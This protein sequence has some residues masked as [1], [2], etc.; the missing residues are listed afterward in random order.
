MNSEDKQAEQ[1][2]NQEDLTLRTWETHWQ[3]AVPANYLRN[4]SEMAHPSRDVIA[5]KVA[6]MGVTVLECGCASAIDYPRYAVRGI[7]YTGV[8]LSSQFL[9]HARE[10]NP[11]VNVVLGNLTKLP[12][13]DQSFDVAF[14]RAVFEHMLPDSETGWPQALKEMWRVARKGIV[15]ALFKRNNPNAKAKSTTDSR[16]KVQNAAISYNR[17]E[18][19]MRR[20]PGADLPWDYT[21]TEPYGRFADAEDDTVNRR[22]YGIYTLRRSD[23]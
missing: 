2:F 11:D 18:R 3:E 21:D 15:V 13:D 20:L 23:A 14:T 9:N 8:D 6:A 22:I 7:D 19:F 10:V 16:N 1:E 12:F 5:D 4:Q 17:L